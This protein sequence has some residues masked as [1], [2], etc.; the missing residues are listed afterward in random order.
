MNNWSRDDVVTRAQAR[1]VFY[2]GQTPGAAG[3]RSLCAQLVRE[4]LLAPA[5]RRGPM[6]AYYPAIAANLAAR[7]VRD[8]IPS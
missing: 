2:V 5:G 4:G 3:L 7:N 1:G 8:R 6:L